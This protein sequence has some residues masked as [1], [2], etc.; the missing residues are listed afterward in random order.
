[1]KAVLG[2][3]MSDTPHIIKHGTCPCI[4]NGTTLVVSPANPGIGQ[5][6]A[7]VF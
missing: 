5:Q 4:L 7:Q 1:M 2:W 3:Y 6:R